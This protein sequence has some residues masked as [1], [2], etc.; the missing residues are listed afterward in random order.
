MK[1]IAILFTISL[2]SLIAYKT[3]YFIGENFFFDKLFYKK[4]HLHGY[5]I[6]GI[7]SLESFP[8]RS[9]DIKEIYN[10]LDA[11]K[12][13]FDNYQ[14]LVDQDIFLINVLGDSYVWGEGVKPEQRFVALLEKKLNKIRPTRVLSLAMSGD[15][16]F[17]NLAKYQ[18]SKKV[19]GEADISIFGMVAND[20]LL[21][22]PYRY[23]SKFADKSFADC[24]SQIVYEQH[25]GKNP[26]YIEQLS[27]VDR[28]FLSADYSSQNWCAYKELASQL[29]S[30]KIIYADLNSFNGGWESKLKIIDQLRKND[31]LVFSFEEYR[32]KNYPKPLSRL[33]KKNPLIITELEGHPS[34]LAHKIF[35]EALFEEITTNPEWGFN[36]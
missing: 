29:P 8:R 17:E 9:Q 32:Q 24:S 28:V 10:Y 22:N 36:K 3:A 5:W 30:E 27:Y 25:S 11:K 34:V 26:E 21:N 31:L 20:L 23:Q 35:A 7:D 16:V 4:S 6:K 2:T 13:G 15:N 33:F 12:N 14:H 1:K 18:I 19:F